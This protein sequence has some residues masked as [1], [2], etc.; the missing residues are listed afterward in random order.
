MQFIVH[1]FS[2][3]PPS[4]LLSTGVYPRVH[5]VEL[6]HYYCVTSLPQSPIIEKMISVSYLERVNNYSMCYGGFSEDMSTE[7]LI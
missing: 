1:P 6:Q 5:V 2:T 7:T 3:C 4:D